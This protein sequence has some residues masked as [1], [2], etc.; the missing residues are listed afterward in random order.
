MIERDLGA[1]ANREYDVLVVGGGIFGACAA[2]DAALRG[3]SV[4][5]IE[6]RDFG[7]G[8]SAN[9][10]KMVHGGI[11]YLQ[12]ADVYRIRESSRERTALLRI[13]P[14][15][16]SPLPVLI[17]TYGHGR[18][19]RELLSAGMLAYDSLTLDRNRGLSDPDRRIPRCRIASRD[20]CLEA[21]PNLE[22]KGLTGGALFHDGQVHNTPR[23][24]LAFL[25]SAG[26]AGAVVANYVE[27][28]G[29]LWNDD[30]V[31][32]VRARDTLTGET[33]EVRSRVVLNCAGAWAERLL[34]LEAD[35][36]LSPGTYSRDACFVVPRRWDAPWALAVQGRTSDPDAIV[37]RKAR[38]LFMVPWRDHTLVGVW[39]Q[40]FDGDP[41][42]LA[43]DESEL[44]T[45][46]DEI[47]WAY[48]AAD[49][50][51]ADVSFVNAGLVLF[52]KNTPGARDLSYGKRSRIVDHAKRHGIEGLISVIGVRAT[53]ARGVAD[54]AVRMTCRQL[55]RAAGAAGTDVVPLV[56][57][58]MATFREELASAR[59][60]YA[61]VPAE[62]IPGLIRNHGSE[63]ERVL[64]HAVD[65]PDWSRPL[66]GTTV[67]KAQ[68]VNAVRD[69]SARKLGDVV[70][71]RTEL[72]SGGDPGDAAIR[73]CARLLSK[74]LA[75]T[76]ARTAAEI[77]EVRAVFPRSG[78]SSTTP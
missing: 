10:F 36:A 55:G 46:I 49:L 28:T 34:S 27:A 4:A 13:A 19:G 15:L 65:S 70:F 9:S 21:L 50:T 35:L 1:L 71:R 44:Q 58:N 67:L 8:T 5:L 31:A 30:A 17:P 76:D 18:E 72:G 20:E 38:H 3:L 42:R 6:R 63:H 48:P 68:V 57:G 61:D 59:A 22:S 32:G 60:R 26:S 29:F 12:H 37:S 41:D 11:R 25:K 78:R 53:T 40:V 16:V 74:E 77:D 23:L 75:W 69:E 14:H 52:G 43:V 33:F 73:E 47:N 62:A 24:V 66:H 64:A 39:H 54:R 2:W 7:S 51:L 56:G 45:F